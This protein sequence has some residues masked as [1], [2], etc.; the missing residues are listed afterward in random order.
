MDQFDGGESSLGYG[1]SCWH[2]ALPADPRMRRVG[3]FAAGFVGVAAIAW[4]LLGRLSPVAEPDRPVAIY[5]RAA[6]IAL[7]ESIRTREGPE[8]NPDCHTRIIIS[9]TPADRPVIVLLHGFTNCPK[10]FDRLA[11]NFS[12]AGYNVVLPLLPRHGLADRMT[13]DLQRL[14]GE[15][16]VRSG[17]TAIDVARGLGGPITVVGLSSSAVLAGWLAQHRSEVDC[18]VLLAPSFAPS[19]WPAPAARRLTVAMLGAPNFF[20]WWDRKV[21]ENLPGPRQCYPRFASHA[22]AE[23]YRLG[24]TVLHEAGR[25]APKAR[26]V[27]LVTSEL[28]TA[29]NNDLSMELVRLWRARGADVQTF[30]FAANLGVQHDMIDPEQPYQRTGVSYPIIEKLVTAA[31]AR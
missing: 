4:L 19:G 28:D 24:F 25:A 8:V 5:D 3:W 12:K 11:A 29:V 16:L 13:T 23:V 26:K 2:E 20:I 15:D 7:V 18:A 22:L 10:Q 9:D 17:Q 6:A 21:R 27:I 1:L 14:R 30:Q 31:A